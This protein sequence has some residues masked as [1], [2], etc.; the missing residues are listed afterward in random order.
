MICFSYLKL[1]FEKLIG[2]QPHP[3][4][5]EKSLPVPIGII[6]KFIISGLTPTSI[7]ELTTH[8]IVPSPPHIITLTFVFIFVSYSKNCK[9]LVLST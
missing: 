7:T 8:K 9:P 2:E 3:R 4:L 6:P 1:F 5:L